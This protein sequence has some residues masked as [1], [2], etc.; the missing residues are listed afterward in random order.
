MKIACLAWGSLVWNRG[1]LPV[2]SW[3]SDGP[4]LSVEF[5]RQSRDGRLTLVRMETGVPCQVLHGLLQA[6]DVGAAVADL[7]AREGCPENRIGKWVNSIDRR[8]GVENQSIGAWA[9]T[10][11]LDAVVWTALGPRFRGTDGRVPSLEE[12]I[13]YLGALA[14]KERALA[15]GYVRRAPQQIIT[16]YRPRIEQEFGWYPE[17]A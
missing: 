13:N 10:R 12:A 9:E 11:N 1:T 7:A 8:D 16:R 3:R 15:E 2:S 4:I 6:A 14:G 17:D 5:A